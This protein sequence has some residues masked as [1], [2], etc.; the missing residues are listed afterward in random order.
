MNWMKKLLLWSLFAMI[1][2]GIA[3]AGMKDVVRYDKLDMMTLVYCPPEAEGD[4]VVPDGVEA[5]DRRAF[6][7]CRKI[8]SLTIPPSVKR[9]CRASDMFGAPLC[10]EFKAVYISDLAAWCRIL[11]ITFDDDEA[12]DLQIPNLYLNG[13]LI[14]DLEIPEGVESI[15]AMAF[16]GCGSL[17]RVVVPKSVTNIGHDAFANCKML[18]EVVIREGKGR[19]RCGNGVFRG[20]S[21]LRRAILPDTLCEI[22]ENMFSECVNL[23]EFEMPKNV[24]FVGDAAFKGCER[25][26]S[27]HI[28][29]SVKKIGRLAFAGCRRLESVKIGL[30]LCVQ[31]V[32]GDAFDGCKCRV[33]DTETIPGF[34]M[35]NGIVVA[36][37]APLG[38]TLDLTGAKGIADYA[39]GEIDGLEKLRHIIFPDGLRSINLEVFEYCGNVRELTIPPSVEKINGGYNIRGYPWKN[40]KKI[41]IRDVA[42]WSRIDFDIVMMCHDCLGTIPTLAGSTNPLRGG[43]ELWLNGRLLTDIVIP[44]SAERVGKAAFYGYEHLRSV[45]IEEGVKEIGDFA[46]YDCSNLV[47]TVIAN[48]VTNIGKKAFGSPQ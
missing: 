23:E 11:F 33:F 48:S 40:F 31:E 15:G 28:H 16:I 36:R 4:V 18:E 41:N 21:L 14:A 20:C 29:D 39:I 17:R 24:E 43:V 32:E 35:L 12:G 47:S 13:S 9:M 38:E 26:R 22:P 25:L 46:F 3:T 6:A 37:T 44:G 27:I 42:A 1:A 7:G 30:G 19:I 34:K 2:C 8:Q 10:R 45:T 5:I